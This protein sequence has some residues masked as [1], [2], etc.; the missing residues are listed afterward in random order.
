[1][2]AALGAT[3]TGDGATMD[4]PAS[5]LE[6]G[7]GGGG[8]ETLGAVVAVEALTSCCSSVFDMPFTGG[9]IGALEG[10]VFESS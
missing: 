3:E 5:G 9:V 7:M 8:S 1:L 6:G 2:R 10:E 4:A